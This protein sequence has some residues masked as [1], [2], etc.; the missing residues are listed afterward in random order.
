[1]TCDLG[2]VCRKYPAG[3]APK[4]GRVR[5]HSERT[6]RRDLSDMKESLVRRRSDGDVLSDL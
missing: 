5:Q 2:V 1:L 4:V 6:G 3:G